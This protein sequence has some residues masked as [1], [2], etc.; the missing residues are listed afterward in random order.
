MTQQRKM[1]KVKLRRAHRTALR[2]RSTG[3][4][5]R[6]AV[7]RSN[8]GIYAQVIDDAKGVTVASAS[9]RDVKKEKNMKKS[10][11]AHRVGEVIAERAVAKGV[12]QAV[13]DRRAYRYHG[14]V[15]AL[16]EGA[17]KAGLKL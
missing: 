6:L 7:F 13:F 15:K 10:D 14:R 2:V 9:S 5:P 12:K 17:R 8:K 11:V 16:A 4:H 3:G 1:Y